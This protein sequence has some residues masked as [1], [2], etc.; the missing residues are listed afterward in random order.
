MKHG[1]RFANDRDIA[2][3]LPGYIARLAES[4]RLTE[5]HMAAGDADAVRKIVHQMKGSGKSYGFDAISTLA[6][7]AESELA[8]GDTARAREHVAELLKYIR[9]IEGFP[10]A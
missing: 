5:Q 1:S 10:P 4:V 6:A 7:I 3:L 9:E 2:P 8:S